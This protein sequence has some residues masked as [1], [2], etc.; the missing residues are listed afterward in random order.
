MDKKIFVV[1]LCYF[2]ACCA[3]SLVLGPFPPVEIVPIN[4]TVSFTCR[5]NSSALPGSSVSAFFWNIKGSVTGEAGIFNTRTFDVTK[6]NLSGIAIWCG[7]FTE[8]PPYRIISSY[9]ATLKVYGQ[10]FYFI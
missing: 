1:A 6:E 9:N 5:V 10:F 2:V 7:V 3:G 8:N 4:S